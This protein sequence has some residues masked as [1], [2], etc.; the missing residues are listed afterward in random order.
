MKQILQSLSTGATDLLDLPS[1]ALGHGQLLIRTSC[2]LVS[3]GTER[4]L[5]EFGKASWIDKARQQPDKVQQVL[6]KTR[7]DGL[8]T[9]FDAVRSKLDQP[10]PL[11]YCN[12][13]SVV[14]V[15]PGVSAF[16]VGDRV[17]S[18]GPHSEL[19]A[20]PQHLCAVIPPESATKLLLSQFLLQLV[21]RA[22]DWPSPPWAKLL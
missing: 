17:A 3:A 12:V 2:S 8:L 13:G 15:G 7:T 16:S 10:L 4:M 9:T 18:N 20:V 5:V 14:A 22:S 6:D 19:V 21:Y 1:P 11:G